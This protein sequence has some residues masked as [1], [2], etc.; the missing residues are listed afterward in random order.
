MTLALVAPSFDAVS[1]TFIAD[2][3]RT[4][5]PGNTVLVCRES[6]GA[7]Q[8]G[9]PVLSHMAPEPVAFGRLD[10]RLKHV[11]QRLRRKYGPSLGYD[12][13]MRLI[14]FF[15]DHK[16]DRVLGE[17][18]YSGVMVADVCRSLGIPLYVYFRGMDASATATRGHMQRRY[19][20]LFAQAKGVFCVSQAIADRVTAM[21]CPPGLIQVNASGVLV[22]RFQPGDPDPNRILAVGRLVDKKAPHLTIEAFARIAPRFPEARLDLVG[23]G[24]LAGRCREAIEAHGLGGR[25]TL[26]GSLPH[27]AVAELMRRASIFA[28]H[29]ITAPNGDIEG[30]PTAIAEAMSC[31]LATV[32]TRHSGIPEH[33]IDGQTGLIVEEG[34]VAGMGEAMAQLLA[35]PGLARRLGASA[36]EHARARLDRERSRQLVRDTMGLPAPQSERK[37]ALRDQPTL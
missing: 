2:H 28:Q 4:L 5:A 32:S 36:R 3:V 35:D 16:V 33:V 6:L 17:F 21:G 26:H 11:L 22:D 37:P 12:D 29:S 10:A 30:F 15:R 20:K 13:R 18:G 1:E 14:A 7:E 24:P 25:V 34:D 19:R 31:E 8:Y 23:D 9:L 27:E